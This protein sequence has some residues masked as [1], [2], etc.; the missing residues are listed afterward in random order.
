M[1]CTEVQAPMIPMSAGEKE[2]EDSVGMGVWFPWARLIN[3]WYILIPK[4]HSTFQLL[5]WFFLKDFLASSFNT[6]GA[7]SCYPRVAFHFR[8]FLSPQPLLSPELLPPIPE[9]RLPVLLAPAP[10]ISKDA[11]SSLTV[12]R[13]PFSRRTHKSSLMRCWNGSPKARQ[14]LFVKV[15][16]SWQVDTGL[17]E[18]CHSGNLLASKLNIYIYIHTEYT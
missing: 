6:A 11:T 4:L 16:W 15:K 13:F 12:R 1:W 8:V 17:A 14:I 3:N 5:R 10:K 7:T 9:R 18:T 2:K